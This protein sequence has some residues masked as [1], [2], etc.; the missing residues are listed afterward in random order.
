M[1]RQ[2]LFSEEG[3]VTTR[4]GVSGVVGTTII[5]TV[6]LTAGGTF[7]TA[8]GVMMDV[9]G[10]V[11]FLALDAKVI[12]SYEGGNGIATVVMVTHFDEDDSFLTWW[13]FENDLII[14]IQGKHHDLIIGEMALE[15]VE[16][17]DAARSFGDTRSL[18]EC[19]GLS[20]LSGFAA[21]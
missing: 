7:L 12:L 21:S 1:I 15:G 8:A 3:A 5:F 6:G 9:I 13:T 16:F 10:L 11:A 17:G 20:G 18:M 2:A 14:M 19:L 4:A